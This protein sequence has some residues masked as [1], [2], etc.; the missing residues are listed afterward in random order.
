MLISC[1]QT[2]KTFTPTARHFRQDGSRSTIPLSMDLLLL[3]Q[4]HWQKRCRV[5]RSSAPRTASFVRDP[6]SRNSFLTKQETRTRRPRLVPSTAVSAEFLFS[7]LRHTATPAV[8][9]CFISVM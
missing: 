9:R 3:M 5:L 6:V 8:L 4:T 1:P 7:E 2:S